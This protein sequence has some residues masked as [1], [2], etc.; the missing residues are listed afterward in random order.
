MN[1]DLV[2]KITLY[3]TNNTAQ[4]GVTPAWNQPSGAYYYIG[5]GINESN[6]LADSDRVFG[7]IPTWDHYKKYYLHS[8][9]Y[10]KNVGADSYS[11][12]RIS[13][14]NTDHTYLDI[15]LSA[16][17]LNDTNG[18]EEI[19]TLNAAPALYGGWGNYVEIPGILGPGNFYH[20]WLR[21]Q[22]KQTVLPALVQADTAV[23]L[24]FLAT[25]IGA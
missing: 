13:V 25:E 5:G 11:E 19:N 2:G 10:I 23:A 1:A 6:P 20:I 16:G 8:S 15:G 12:M 9:F 14:A 3:G 24:T 18:A 17:G 22:P 21:R 7:D 4:T